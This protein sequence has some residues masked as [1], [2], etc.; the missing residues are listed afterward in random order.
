MDISAN[1]QTLP[2]TSGGISM[3]NIIE[4]MYNGD[5]FPS[6]KL[7]PDD[8]EYRR[9]LDSLVEAESALLKKYPEIRELFNAYQNAQIAIINISNRMEFVNGF[10]VGA[11]IAFEMIKPIK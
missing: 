3:S 4:E 11:Q 10:K 6:G 8:N 2:T 5:L 7:N 1:N 9:A